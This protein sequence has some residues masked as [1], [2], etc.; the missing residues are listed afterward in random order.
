QENL[1]MR[2][3]GIAGLCVS[4]GVFLLSEVVKYAWDYGPRQQEREMQQQMLEAALRQCK[5][6][7]AQAAEPL[8]Q[9]LRD[10]EAVRN[11]LRES[12]VRHEG[13]RGDGQKD[14]PRPAHDWP[15][16]R[17]NALQT[18][19]AVEAL[20]DQLEVLWKFTAKDSIE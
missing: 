15:I 16:F 14:I 13:E 4:L 1:V 5:D 9:W 11:S 19:V 3:A 8:Q 10:T 12:L 17:G 18:G 2:N 6:L 7:D 20:P